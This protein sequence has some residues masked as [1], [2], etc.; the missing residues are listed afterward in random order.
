LYV[1]FF[2]RPRL[3]SLFP[4]HYFLYHCPCA[5]CHAHH[6]DYHSFNHDKAILTTS[7][8]NP[9][10]PLD[11]VQVT[12]PFEALHSATTSLSPIHLANSKYA[13]MAQCAI[14]AQHP[15]HPFDFSHT[16]P[17]LA[18]ASPA[19]CPDTNSSSTSIPKVM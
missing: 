11:F 13:N 3:H 5:Q 9:F 8:V 15:A 1:F 7:D 2:F 17:I 4:D 16:A 14:S 12:H 6:D 10:H 19:P 18:H